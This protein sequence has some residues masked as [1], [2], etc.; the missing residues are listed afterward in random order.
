[1][2]RETMILLIWEALKM[3]GM[4]YVTIVPSPMALAMPFI[5][6]QASLL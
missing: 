6:E 5:R 3:C 2:M 1:M 4:D